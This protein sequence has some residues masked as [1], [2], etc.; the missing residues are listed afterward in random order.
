MARFAVIGL[1]RFGMSLATHL[2]EAGAEVVAIDADRRVIEN[3]KDEVT[4]AVALDA[5]DEHALRAQNLE[6]V[7][8]AI[9][10]IGESFEANQLATL[11]LKNI[12]VKRII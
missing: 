5:T 4:V 10:C 3:I 8:A 1:G 12:G 6:K 2:T 11:L 9:V 7:D